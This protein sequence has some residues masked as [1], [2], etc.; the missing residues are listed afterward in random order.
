MILQNHPP[1]VDGSLSRLLG[2]LL[3][4]SRIS[5]DDIDELLG[6]VILR[7]LIVIL[8][9][10]R[11]N[12]RRRN[13]QDS[14]HHPIGATPKATEAHEV[15]ILIAD[16]AEKAIDILGFQE[17]TRGG[18]FSSGTSTTG[19]SSGG[20]FR[21]RETLPFCH[22]ATEILIVI[23]VRLPCT[24]TVLRLLSAARDILTGRQDGLPAILPLR[25]LHALGR[26]LVNE[27]F[28]TLDANTT[29]NLLNHLEKLILIDR[30]GQMM[31]TKVAR[32]A[33]IVETTRTTELSILEDSHTGI[34]KTADLAFLGVGRRNLHHRAPDNLIR[35]KDGKLDANQCLGF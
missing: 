11:A 25:A 30:P 7:T 20:R 23:A 4:K 19:C 9:D 10:G 21:W 26:L 1:L 14:A 15:H 22:N 35:A 29:Q 24:A 3:R 27:E 32:A 6:Q 31:M 5:L 13:C 28:T 34:R 33:V 18:I 17:A 8:Q 12:L 16:T 2:N